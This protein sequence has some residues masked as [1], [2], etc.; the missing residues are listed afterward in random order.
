MTGDEHP[1]P[2]PASHK[3]GIAELI[4][5]AHRLAPGRNRAS[6]VFV[7]SAAPTLQSPTP[8]RQARDSIAPHRRC[9]RQHHAG[10]PGILAAS[11]PNTPAP[12]FFSRIST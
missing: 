1:H 7:D 3:V 10:K 6:I 12:A 5:V 11:A 8:R 9:S 2:V 4:E